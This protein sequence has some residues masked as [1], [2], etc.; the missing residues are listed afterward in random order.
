MTLYRWEAVLTETH[1]SFF[2]KELYITYLHYSIV[3]YYYNN[4]R[5]IPTIIHI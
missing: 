2:T 5:I 4:A 3:Y 1:L